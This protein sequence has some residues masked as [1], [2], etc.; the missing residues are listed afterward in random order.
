MTAA[1][2]A[3]ARGD[4]RLG[5][6]LG[7]GPFDG[8][9]VLQHALHLRS[10]VSVLHALLPILRAS[11]VLATRHR[12]VVALP[13]SSGSSLVSRHH[14]ASAR[15]AHESKRLAIASAPGCADSRTAARTVARLVT[16]S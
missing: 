11:V 15:S 6:L 16:N 9:R 1:R 10:R 13:H 7:L 8:Y 3:P 4:D 5:V 14:V 12:R 2:W